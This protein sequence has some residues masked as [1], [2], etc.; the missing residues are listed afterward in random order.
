MIDYCLPM[1][2]TTSVQRK[3]PTN[4]TMGRGDYNQHSVES[5]V[6]R[7]CCQK[8]LEYFRMIRFSL[9]ALTYNSF[10]SKSIVLDTAMEP[11]FWIVDRLSRKIG[12]IM[13]VLV[14]VLTT[15]VVSFFYI[16]LLP[17]L[18][19]RG[20]FGVITFHWIFGHWLLVNIVF[21]YYKGVTT[22]PGEPPQILSDTNVATI[23][24]RCVGPKP[25]RTHHCS[26]CNHCIL[27]M[28]H[29]CPWLNNCVGHFN[30]RYFML[31][32]IYMWLGTLY[33][34]ISVWD[35]FAEE[36]FDAKKTFYSFFSGGLLLKTIEVYK[37]TQT[38]GT[39][40]SPETVEKLKNMGG[41]SFSDGM[42]HKVVC[43]EFFL[44]IGVMIALGALTA[45][46]ARLICRGETSVEKHINDDERKRLKKVN[47]IYKNPY[48]FGAR[49][50]WR[51]FLGLGEGRSFVRH[52]IFPSSHVP[53]G[54]G[55]SW[56]H[57]LVHAKEP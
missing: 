28:D 5:K 57:S 50:N 2:E 55:L 53:L 47:V 15:Y 23:C 16:I 7:T 30:H 11:I 8:I 44:C 51:I 13:V 41:L 22:P 14:V 46:H 25:P 54:S 27:K 10:T 21:H 26:V 37:A 40:L 29:H 48:D 19:N 39:T 43:L 18:W 45:W 20:Q 4:L 38:N 17:Y 32:C 42:Y 31:F 1:N 49:E 34:C 12:P 33:V 9:R 3:K 6:H 52:I 36:F 24:K 56:P 35:I